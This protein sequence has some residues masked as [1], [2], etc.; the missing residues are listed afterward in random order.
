[1]IDLGELLRDIGAVAI[2][3]LCAIAGIGAILYFAG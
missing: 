1:M 3:V 2:I